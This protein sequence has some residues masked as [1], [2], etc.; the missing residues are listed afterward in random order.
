MTAAPNCGRRHRDAPSRTAPLRVVVGLVVAVALLSIA[1]TARSAE[2]YS[3]EEVKAAFL[4]HF[5]TYV[6]WPTSSGPDQVITFTV[7]GA[8]TIAI[9]LERFAA[10]RTIH[11]RAVHIRQLQSL[12]ESDGEQV[13]FIGASH[14]RRLAEMIAEVTTPTLI[15]TDTP[16]GLAHGAMINFQLVERRV[17]FEIAVPPAQE[18]GLELSSRLLSA[19]MRVEM[20]NCRV[21]CDGVE[22][23]PFAEILYAVLSTPLQ[24]RHAT[25]PFRM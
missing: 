8:P 2:R 25:A 9:E 17:R 10:G 20:S 22:R 6:S 1:C 13:L 18:A 16:E 24:G 3:E 14:N 11:G 12:D 7:I 5:A 21:R 19:A 23:I 15:V 4:Y